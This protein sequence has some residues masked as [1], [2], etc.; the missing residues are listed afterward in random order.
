MA[1]AVQIIQAAAKKSPFEGLAQALDVYLKPREEAFDLLVKMEATAMGDTKKLKKKLELIDAKLNKAPRYSAVQQFEDQIN[2]AAKSERDRQERKALALNKDFYADKAKAEKSKEDIESDIEDMQKELFGTASIQDVAN[3]LKDDHG[4]SHPGMA[5]VKNVTT[6][7]ALKELIAAGNL[8]NTKI[9]TTITNYMMS[10]YGEYRDEDETSIAG[11][12]L[13]TGGK[14]YHTDISPTLAAQL[15]MKEYGL[16]ERTDEIDGLEGVRKVFD[17]E[18]DSVPI[19]LSGISGAGEVQDLETIKKALRKEGEKKL[20][21][22]TEKDA[23]YKRQNEALKQARADILSDLDLAQGSGGSLDPYTAAMQKARERYGM[24]KPW[25]TTYVSATP[26]DD[27]IVEMM[28]DTTSST[29]EEATADDVG[30]VEMMSDTTSSTGEEATKDTSK[31]KEEATE[32]EVVTS[33]VL[34]EP[35][36]SKKSV[37]L[38]DTE[39]GEVDAAPST[40]L[41]EKEEV[42]VSP[43]EALKRQITEKEQIEREEALLKERELGVDVAQ[44]QSPVATD[45]DRFLAS[46]MYKPQPSTKPLESRIAEEAI[47]RR[48]LPPPEEVPKVETDEGEEERTRIID[49]L[50]EWYLGAR[51]ARKTK[52]KTEEPVVEEEPVEESPIQ[53]KF[54]EEPEAVDE[55]LEAVEKPDYSTFLPEMRFPHKKDGITKYYSYK[56]TG[57][58]KEGEPKFQFI[59][60]DGKPSA[61]PLNE[62]QTKEALDGQE[63]KGGGF[64]EKYKEEYGVEFSARPIAEAPQPVEEAPVEDITQFLEK[65]KDVPFVDRIL[66]PDKYPVQENPGGTVS[67]H[68][69]AYGETK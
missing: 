26:E 52:K 23:Y 62:A 51:K 14:K 41:I 38:K 61:R 1:S 54:E 66:N 21:S 6:P 27:E 57:Y 55:A 2:K 5:S 12:Y 25:H 50:K 43:E 11:D 59:S 18:K 28:S 3:M 10:A 15:Y 31:K 45:L 44:E 22:A 65:N 30:F 20:A 48:P 64:K 13:R 46:Q 60:K 56:V 49:S 67:T 53:S 33:D 24:T 9:Q 36:Y 68:L 4:D 17:T 58:D 63:N 34:I 47:A 32:T 39:L 40:E 19:D 29:G 7:S 42:D 37:T 69:M 16:G 8:D 35:S